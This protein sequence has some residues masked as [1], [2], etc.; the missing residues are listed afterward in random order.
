M[1]EPKVKPVLKSCPVPTNVFTGREDILSQLHK[2]FAPSATS[3]KQRR[4][5]LYG[6]GGGG[7]SQIGFKF[8][9]ECQETQPPR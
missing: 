3:I 7:K 6:L 2:C 8:V 4:F 9:S 5:V 1:L